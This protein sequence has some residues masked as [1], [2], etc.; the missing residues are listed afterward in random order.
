MIP[1]FNFE[2]TFEGILFRIIAS[3]GIYLFNGLS[4]I[5][6]TFLYRAFVSEFVG[7]NHSLYAI[8]YDEWDRGLRLD[9]ADLDEC[10]IIML[11]RVDMYNDLPKE[12]IEELAKTKA[13]FLDFKEIPYGYFDSYTGYIA[14]QRLKN[15]IRVAC[16]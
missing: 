9:K 3:P 16:A 5:G 6:K 11:D 7:G 12:Q 2:F 1:K 14:I 15:E 13:I 4:G 8:T 10:E